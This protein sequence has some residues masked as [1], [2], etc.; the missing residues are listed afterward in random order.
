MLRNL[1]LR[2]LLS[3]L[4]REKRER[5]SWQ[6]FSWLNKPLLKSVK[7]THGHHQLE[8][9]WVQAFPAVTGSL[10]PGFAYKLDRLPLT[11]FSGKQVDWI[12]FIEEFKSVIGNSTL[13]NVTKLRY[14]LKYVDPVTRSALGN[15]ALF[16]L[17]YTA[18]MNILEDRFGDIQTN[19]DSH[20]KALWEIPCPR[21]TPQ[22]LL[23]FYDSVESHIRALVNLGKKE[24]QLGEVY[25]SII[26]LKLPLS[27][28]VELRRIR[29][30]KEWKFQQWRTELFKEIKNRCDGNFETTPSATGNHLITSTET[31]T[32]PTAAFNVNA[33]Y[34]RPRPRSA[35][36]SF[37]SNRPRSSSA[38]P[39]RM[40]CIYCR[41]TDHRANDCNQVT[42]PY[43]RL[44]IL[45]TNKLCINCT[46]PHSKQNCASTRGCST[47]NM[48]HH[49][50]LHD[51]FV[52]PRVRDETDLSSDN[53][54]LPRS[55]QTSPARMNMCA[56]T[57]LYHPRHYQWIRTSND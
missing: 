27:V 22:S 31:G 35:S 15:L 25:C 53:K 23:G 6:D 26:R 48:K 32:L 30:G 40:N 42:D 38:S 4:N 5:D 55:R 56:W 47:C 50:S 3:L 34:Q 44:E 12:A 45:M 37:R 8:V 9:P 13:P 51:C 46:G 16:D 11:S 49:T 21:D 19:F 24:D 17:N 1:K 52:L 54:N 14:L 7:L 10:S 57:C 39:S 20:I 33:S 28:R 36:P 41:Q 2:L 29:N 18:A 43:Q